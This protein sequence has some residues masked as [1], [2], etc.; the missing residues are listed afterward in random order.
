MLRPIL[1]R[2]TASSSRP[3]TRISTCTVGR[4]QGCRAPNG[5]VRRNLRPRSNVVRQ[6]STGLGF[7]SIMHMNPH[8]NDRPFFQ[9]RQHTAAVA[10]SHHYTTDSNKA[11][12]HQQY[13]IMVYNT[14]FDSCWSSQRREMSDDTSIN[15]DINDGSDSDSGADT[16]TGTNGAIAKGDNDGNEE[17]IDAIPGAQKGGKKL[18][19]VFTCNVCDTRSAKQFTENAYQNGVVIVTCPG[20]GSKHLIA[21]NLG[22]FEDERDGGWNIEKA[23]ARMGENAKLV[24]NDNVMEVS[25]EDLYGADRIQA[26]TESASKKP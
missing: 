15:I 4:I 3:R 6:F 2:A 16:I 9:V 14:S 13:R 1:L 24:N 12:I 11:P 25:A 22:F 19:I 7:E 23:M 10:T 5:A 18:A 26:A 20:C 21:D 17:E 8:S